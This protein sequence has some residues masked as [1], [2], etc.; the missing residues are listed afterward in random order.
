M[1]RR[2]LDA[3]TLGVEVLASAAEAHAE[4]P[5]HAEIL[6]VLSTVCIQRATPAH[7]EAAERHAKQGLDFVVKAHGDKSLEAAAIYTTLALAQQRLSWWVGA[8][9]D[10]P[11][12]TA[13]ERFHMLTG[14]V[15]YRLADAEAS[16]IKALDIREAV[17]VADDLRIAE[18]LC[19]LCDVHGAK[20]SLE[21]AEEGAERCMYIR[22]A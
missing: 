20:G 12:D 21:R 3:E 5:L 6:S 22:Q 7:L 4:S 16:C 10:L 15:K 2:Y 11:S 18:S 17:C 19:V 9:T 14:R 8:Q 13:C 1:I